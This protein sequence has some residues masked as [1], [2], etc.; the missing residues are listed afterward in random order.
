MSQAAIPLQHPIEGCVSAL[1]AALDAAVGS[2]PAYLSAGAKRHVLKELSRQIGRLEGL[3]LAVLAAAGDVAE[4]EGARSPGAWLAVEAKL[5]RPEGR[6]L[7]K[8]AEALDKR[9]LLVAGGLLDGEVSRPQAHSIVV[10]MDELPKDLDQALRAQAEK[11]LV[12]KAAE[13][14][15]RELRILGRRILDV[16]APAVAEKYERD[17]LERAERRA[18]LRMRV[19]RRELG[20]GLV[21]ITADLPTLHADLLL[22]QLH[23]FSS[24]RRDHLEKEG[25]GV[26]DRRDPESGER[27]PYSRLLAQGFCSLLERLPKSAAPR[28]GGDAA[29][30][31]ITIDHEKLLRDLGVARLS[32]GHAISVGEARRLACNAGILPMVLAGGSQPLDVGRKKRFHTPAMRKAL[33]VR[34]RECRANG[35][36]IPAAWCEAHHVIAWAD[37]RGP[38]N[39]DD[40]LLLCSYHHHRAHDTRYDTSRL[41]NGDLRFHR[42]P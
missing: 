1:A 8:L 9:Y 34:D 35:C 29:S 28:Q 7:Q 15:P 22:T 38:T 17:A 37:A 4:E 41:P 20:E 10:A 19:T 42:R 23:A 11:Y 5:E 12:E 25:L 36:E 33:A 24:P 32:T 3:R 13:F 16:V 39:V 31:V 40:A 18:R 21:R 14:G 30:L 6:Q 2:S 27:V 26:I